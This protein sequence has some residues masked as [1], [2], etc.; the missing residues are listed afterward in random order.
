MYSITFN[1]P[2][3]LTLKGIL[4][5]TYLEEGTTFTREKVGPLE[6][7]DNKFDISKEWADRSERAWDRARTGRWGGGR[8]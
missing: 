1:G 8:W 7:G 2:E 4:G 5:S 3:G 6:E